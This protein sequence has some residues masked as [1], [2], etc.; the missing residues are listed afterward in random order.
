MV[1][2]SK[3]NDDEDI[4]LQ[5]GLCGSSRS[6]PIYNLISTNEHLQLFDRITGS[7]RIPCLSQ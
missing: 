6:E 7:S 2:S 3:V 4:E 1:E 5:P